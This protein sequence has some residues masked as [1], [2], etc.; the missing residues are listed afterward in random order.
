MD[1]MSEVKPSIEEEIGKFRSFTT[2]LGAVVFVVIVGIMGWVGS[3]VQSLSKSFL[4]IQGNLE[5]IN[6]KQDSTERILRLEQG[7][8]ENKIT[9]RI[10]ALESRVSDHR[11]WLDQMWP[12]LRALQENQNKV[13]DA[14]IAANPNIKLELVSPDKL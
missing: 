10:N 12:R 3:E 8:V 7:V 14:L 1:K 5:S 13:R 6:A 9:T 2:G 11:Q 4:I